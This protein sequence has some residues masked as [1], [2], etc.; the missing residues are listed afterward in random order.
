VV[1]NLSLLSPEAFR[2]LVGMIL[3]AER[4][5]RGGLKTS[6]M[7][8]LEKWLITGAALHNP[9]TDEQLRELRFTGLMTLVYR[10]VRDQGV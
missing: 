7:H 3:E 5:A 2:D 8:Q 4:E 10:R 9:W 1:S 6:T